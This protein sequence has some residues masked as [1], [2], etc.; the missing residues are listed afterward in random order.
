VLPIEVV[1]FHWSKAGARG[2]VD[3]A[4]EHQAHRT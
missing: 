2:D 3:I 4:V 1:Q